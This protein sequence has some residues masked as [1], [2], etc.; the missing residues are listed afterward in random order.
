VESIPEKKF[1]HFIYK[2]I[3]YP[4]AVDEVLLDDSAKPTKQVYLGHFEE[5]TGVPPV[6]S[7]RAGETLCL[8]VNRINNNTFCRRVP[9]FREYLDLISFKGD[10][11][12]TVLAINDEAKRL[13]LHSKSGEFDSEETYDCM[14]LEPVYSPVKIELFTPLE[15]LEIL[16]QAIEGLYEMRSNENIPLFTS[17]IDIF[18]HRDLK[19]SN[20]VLDRKGKSFT[21]KLIDF[22]SLKMEGNLAADA[23]IASPLS[24][25][26]TAPEYLG[27]AIWDFEDGEGDMEGGFGRL[28]GAG[29]RHKPIIDPE[30]P[31]Y[32][33]A[34]ERSDVFALGMMLCEAFNVCRMKKPLKTKEKKI[35]TNPLHLWVEHKSR[36]LSGYDK[37]S[38]D[39]YIKAYRSVY[40]KGISAGD[41][42]T[43]KS[44]LELD[45]ESYGVAFDFPDFLPSLRPLVFA[46]TRFDP[47]DRIG[48]DAFFEGIKALIAEARAAEEKQLFSV[49]LVDLRDLDNNRQN[50][51]ARMLKLQKDQPDIFLPYVIYYNNTADGKGRAGFLCHPASDAPALLTDPVALYSALTRLSEPS[52]DGEAKES[53]CYALMILGKALTDE[54]L[55][56]ERFSGNVHIFTSDLPQKES[57]DTVRGADIDKLLANLRALEDSLAVTAHAYSDKSRSDPYCTYQKLNYFGHSDDLKKKYGT[58]APAPSKR[59]SLDSYQKGD[60]ALFVRQKG[61]AV[62]ISRADKKNH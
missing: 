9:Q 17:E 59:L 1:R 16:R 27:D 11:I 18:A 22:A 19:Y 32:A 28:L 14:S 23:T 34:S 50:F 48:T 10:H 36:E 26:N 37:R 43:Q 38:T 7:L 12:R 57:L 54:T 25:S 2:E 33:E 6:S 24:P 39:F 44:W 13:C 21:V 52:A 29:D 53:L 3:S 31:L 61:D 35:I 60:G 46:A 40:A 49:C 45:L 55:D 42:S 41:P 15:R 30:D 51:L 62:F 4:F 8:K 58:T 47:G 5:S 56:R 20:L